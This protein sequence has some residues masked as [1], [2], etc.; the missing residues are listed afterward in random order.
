VAGA[1]GN[2]AFLTRVVTQLARSGIT[3][4]VDVGCGLPV[5]VNV[6]EIAQRVNPDSRVVYVDVDPIVLVYARA[7]LASDSRTIV[8]A[9]DLR[10]PRAVL[11]SPDIREHLDLSRPVAV[12]L[13]A[14]LHFVRDEEDPAG[15]VATFRDALVPGSQIAISHVADMPDGGGPSRAAATRQAVKV[16]QDL[17]GPFVLRSRAQVTALFAGLDVWEPGVVPVRLWRPARG[18]FGPV[19]PVLGGVGRVTRPGEQVQDPAAARWPRPRD[20]LRPRLR[21]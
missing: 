21:L 16:Y 12:L 7:L 9:G 6:H 20:G 4:F 5:A 17:A 8:V 15:I 14:V 3:Q 13:L 10:D 2:R 19:V 11:G 1:R 18:R